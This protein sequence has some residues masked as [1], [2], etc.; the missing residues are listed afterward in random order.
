MYVSIN[1]SHEFEGKPSLTSVILEIPVYFR[2]CDVILL[3]L[4][5]LN[6][7]LTLSG[8]N[9]R[10]SNVATE[11][12]ELKPSKKNGQPKLDLP[13]KLEDFNISS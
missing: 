6:D 8:Q 7:A 12:Y 4:E 9:L 3:S 11:N 2:V 1:L 10:L 5:K 13:G